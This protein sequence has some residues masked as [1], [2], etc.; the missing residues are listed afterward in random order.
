MLRAHIK[1]KELFIKLPFYILLPTSIV[2]HTMDYALKKSSSDN[3]NYIDV[4]TRFGMTIGFEAVYFAF[5]IGSFCLLISACILVSTYIKYKHI[6]R[7]DV[8]YIL[9]A[10]AIHPWTI[11]IIMKLW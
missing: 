1:M 10:L 8:K 5:A 9:L 6:D 7:K 11:S 4:T 3:A 2:F